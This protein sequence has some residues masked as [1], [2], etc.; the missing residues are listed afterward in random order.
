MHRNMYRRLLEWKSRPDRK[1]LLL[2]GARQAGKTYL[3]NQF[4]RQEYNDCAY[5]N[6]EQSPELGSLFAGSLVPETLIESLGAYVGRKIRPGSTLIF[7]DEIQAFPRVITSLKYFCEQAPQYH[8]VSAGSLLGVSVGKSTSFPVGKVNFMTNH[9]HSCFM[10]NSPAYSSITSLSAGC[11]KSCGITSRTKTFNRQDSCRKRS[12]KPIN[13]I[14]QNIQPQAKPCGS[15]KSGVLF[16][17]NW[18]KRTKNS[19]TATSPKA[20]GRLSLKPQP[21]GCTKPG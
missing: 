21:N 3:L 6:F 18:Q 2:Q 16:P 1:P 11:R 12:W 20:V 13:G 8:V 7:F 5:F 14:S 9:G 15:P 17:V 19:N 10:K 4:A